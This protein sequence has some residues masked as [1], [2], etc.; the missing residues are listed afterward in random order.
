MKKTQVLE[1][2]SRFDF[3]EF[4]VKLFLST[5]LLMIAVFLAILAFTR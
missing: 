2:Y 5:G 1:Q 3:D 4:S